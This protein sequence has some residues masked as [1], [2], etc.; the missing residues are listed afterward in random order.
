MSIESSI[1]D[2]IEPYFEVVSV[3]RDFAAEPNEIPFA[4]VYSPDE[5]RQTISIGENTQEV[6][7]TINIDFIVEGDEVD[8][9]LRD[10]KIDVIKAVLA[11]RKL[12]GTALFIDV[13]RVTSDVQVDDSDVATGKMRIILSAQY[14]DN[15]GV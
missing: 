14:I 5:T 8:T 9:L 15:I 10:K 3:S 1:K 12:G 6:T 4:V 11:D 7:A 2:A 13:T